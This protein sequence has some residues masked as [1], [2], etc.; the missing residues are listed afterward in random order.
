MHRLDRD[1]ARLAD[2]DIDEVD[3]LLAIHRVAQR[4]AEVLVVEELPLDRILDVEV[5]QQHR[6]VGGQILHVHETEI[7]AL[8]PIEEDR[9]VGRI[10]DVAEYE[11]EVARRRLER[12]Q[13]GI[14][15]LCPR[16]AVDIG[17][18]VPFGIGLPVVG[19]ARRDDPFAIGVGLRQDPGVHR[20][21]VEVLPV[22]RLEAQRDLGVEER[23]PVR[24]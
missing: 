1:L 18:L 12:H 9:A 3:D 8:L 19:I 10:I 22:L 17:K 16:D 23:H 14:V 20:R 24:G 5:Q 7:A 13:L 15:D 21:E 6:V 11:V 2:A 4:D